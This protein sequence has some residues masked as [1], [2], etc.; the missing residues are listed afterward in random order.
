MLTQKSASRKGSAFLVWRVESCT[1]GNGG[2]EMSTEP[3][4]SVLKNKSPVLKSQ[5]FECGTF[6]LAWDYSAVTMSAV[7]AR[8]NLI[9]S[10][11]A[12]SIW[13]PIF[14]ALTVTVLSARTDSSITVGKAFF[15]P[16]GEQP[17]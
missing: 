15:I 5:A 13:R 12:S 7:L 2:A 1:E 4:S 9:K 3:C 11:G 14:P 8:V 10:A 16:T 17:P 6:V